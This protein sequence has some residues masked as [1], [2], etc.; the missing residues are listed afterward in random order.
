M[1]A[2]WI[3]TRKLRGLGKCCAI[4]AFAA[5]LG[6]VHSAVFTDTSQVHAQ[7]TARFSRVDVSGNQRIAADTIRTIAGIN[8]GN[9]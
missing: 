1:N 9:G 8:A 7:A 4:A 6:P 2:P 5:V 3:A